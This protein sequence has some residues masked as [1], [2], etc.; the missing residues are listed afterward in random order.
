MHG[1]VMGK[2]KTSADE[3]ICP[4][5]ASHQDTRLLFSEVTLAPHCPDNH[6]IEKECNDSN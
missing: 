4:C 2:G 6:G 1:H 5:Q 3:E